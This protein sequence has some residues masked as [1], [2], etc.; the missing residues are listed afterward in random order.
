MLTVC[1]LL[2]ALVAAVLPETNAPFAL[3][4]FLGV[5]WLVAT[6]ATVDLWTLVAAAAVSLIH[7][8]ATLAASGPPGTHLDPTLVRRW[9]VRTLGC[10]AAAA[11]V[12]LVALVLSSLERRPSAV[13][14]GAALVLVAGWTAF[15]TLRLAWAH[16]RGEPPS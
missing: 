10:F 1:G 16:T 5:F 9:Q 8:A 7:V 4:M 14:L 3:L 15:V 2:L 13:A 12:W 11:G 6:P